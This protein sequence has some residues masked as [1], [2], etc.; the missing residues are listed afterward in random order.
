MSTKP[1]IKQIYEADKKNLAF[2]LAAKNVDESLTERERLNICFAEQ[3]QA[4]YIMQM[5]YLREIALPAI[6]KKA[7]RDSDIYK[8]YFTIFE[9][10]MYSLKLIDRDTIN[11]MKISNE[12]TLN[13]FYRK[14]TA[15]YEAEL[16]KYTTIDD[17]L[18]KETANDLINLNYKI[19][20]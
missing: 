19:N 15:F 13:S 5:Q 14:K 20:V 9:S 10:L 4:K 7:G 2:L 17:L 12:N 3:P 18:N 6:E 1:L 16:M 11:R 8:M